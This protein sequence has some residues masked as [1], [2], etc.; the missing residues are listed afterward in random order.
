MFNCLFFFLFEGQH[1]L[2][3]KWVIFWS[4][5]IELIQERHLDKSKISENFQKIVVIVKIVFH[6]F[7]FLTV[8]MCQTSKVFLPFSDQFNDI[9]SQL[10][11]MVKTIWKLLEFCLTHL[12]F[13]CFLSHFELIPLCFVFLSFCLSFFIK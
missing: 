12:S 9:K 13:K 2:Q 7:L 1:T 4:K 3:H 6:S 10:S 5:L 11:H 8:V